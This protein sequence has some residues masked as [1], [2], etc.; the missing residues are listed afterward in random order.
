MVECGEELKHVDTRYLVASVYEYTRGEESVP[1]GP[2]PHIEL[3]MKRAVEGASYKDRP[4]CKLG[5]RRI[6]RS[7]LGWRVGQPVLNRGMLE[8]SE[9]R[10]GPKLLIEHIS[11]LPSLGLLL[12][13]RSP[14]LG[15]FVRVRKPSPRA[16]FVCGIPR[17]RDILSQ[18]DA[19]YACAA[20]KVSA[21]VV[22]R[23][24]TQRLSF[25]VCV[26]LRPL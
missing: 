19:N 7:C 15:E 21:F 11:E 20:A 3:L 1:H 9:R 6:T 12:R 18:S 8:G 5:S 14:A 25:F 2:H 16:V 13:R 4:T 17:M 24:E 26:P 10:L 22:R 23:L